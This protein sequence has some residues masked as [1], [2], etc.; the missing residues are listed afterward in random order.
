M[1]LPLD[2]KIDAQADNQHTGSLI[3]SSGRACARSQKTMQAAGNGKNSKQETPE[4]AGGDETRAK[5]QKG[6]AFFLTYRRN[7]L[8]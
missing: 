3:D 7:E 6:R 5:Q 8:R 1:I 2:G 4:G